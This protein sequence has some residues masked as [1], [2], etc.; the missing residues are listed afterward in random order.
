MRSRTYSKL[1]RIDTFEERF[2]YLALTGVVGEST[3]GFDRY[4]NQMF[5]SSSEW[6]RVRQ[7]VIARDNGCDL[8]IVGHEIHK[9]TPIYIHH[10]N[11]MTP[12]DIKQIRNSRSRVSDQCHTSDAQRYSLW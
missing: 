7:I 9:P 8:G 6:K 11:P 10:M 4:M 2:R 5:Y 3:F 1:Q 12:D